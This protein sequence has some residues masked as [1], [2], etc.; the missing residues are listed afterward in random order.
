LKAEKNI[1]NINIIN[2]NI[3]NN[4]INNTNRREWGNH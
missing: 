2:I 1:I 4:I 3:I